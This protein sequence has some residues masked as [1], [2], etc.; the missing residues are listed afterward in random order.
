MSAS[1]V[2]CQVEISATS[3]SL[4][5][6]SP[7]NCNTSLCVILETSWM[8]GLWPTGGRGGCCAK[9]KQTNQPP[10]HAPN[11][12]AHM[13]GCRGRSSS[14]FRLMTM[15]IIIVVSG[16]LSTKAEAS[17]ET[18]RISRIATASRDSSLTA[19]TTASVCRPIQPIKPRRDKAWQINETQLTISK[20]ALSSFLFLRRWYDDYCLRDVMVCSVVDKAKISEDLAASIFMV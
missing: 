10:R 17:A 20:S 9:N 13:R 1:V 15:R 3:W 2:C 12:S 6:R 7:T 16:M 11:A 19:R 5:Q 4:V 18:H 8:R 14:W